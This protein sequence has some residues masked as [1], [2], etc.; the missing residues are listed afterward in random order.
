MTNKKANRYANVPI[1]IISIGDGS[2]NATIMKKVYEIILNSSL[3]K[4]DN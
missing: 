4:N 3:Q 1:T 2:Q